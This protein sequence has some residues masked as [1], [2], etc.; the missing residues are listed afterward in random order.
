MLEQ[1]LRKFEVPVEELS[2]IEF[3]Y[4]TKSIKRKYNQIKR[5]PE[6]RSVSRR[7]IMEYATVVVCRELSKKEDNL[8]KEDE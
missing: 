2:D 3:A 1:T 5:I 8:K 4:L 7:K 6:N